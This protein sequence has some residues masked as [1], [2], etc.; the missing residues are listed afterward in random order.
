MKVP[1]IAKNEKVKRALAV[2]SPV[3]GVRAIRTKDDHLDV[4]FKADLGGVAL[5]IAAARS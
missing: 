2:V 5:A 4:H 1:A 3:V